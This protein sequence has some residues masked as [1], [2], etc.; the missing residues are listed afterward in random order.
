MKI[1]DDNITDLII[2]YKDD[3]DVLNA[4]LRTKKDL[5]YLDSTIGLYE[6]CEYCDYASRDK[7]NIGYNFEPAKYCPMCGK[8]FK[9]D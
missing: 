7:H 1:L 4:I 6:E 9:E 2:K 5:E 8:T 3:H